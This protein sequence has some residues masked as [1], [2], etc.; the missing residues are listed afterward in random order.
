MVQSFRVS[1]RFYD[2]H[3]TGTSPLVCEALE[4]IAAFYA[5]EARISGTSLDL[6]R[7]VRQEH[8]RPLAGRRQRMA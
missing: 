5:I 1:G 4:R 8:A 7:Q 2:I 3:A 6:R